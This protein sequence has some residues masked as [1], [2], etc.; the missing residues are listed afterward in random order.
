MLL[1][2][3]FSHRIGLSSLFFTIFPAGDFFFAFP[4]PT[5]P[6]TLK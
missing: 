1:N 5:Y 6:V 3:T 2:R 4:L